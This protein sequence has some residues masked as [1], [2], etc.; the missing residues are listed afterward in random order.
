MDRK[1]S[2]SA[3]NV[4]ELLVAGMTVRL[5]SAEGTA[6]KAAIK[7]LL[8]RSPGRA[9]SILISRSCQTG[10]PERTRWLGA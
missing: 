5:W 2:Y 10:T 1:Y 7:R 6:G 8:N 9:S 3:K 4:H